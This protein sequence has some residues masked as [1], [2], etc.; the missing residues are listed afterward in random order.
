MPTYHRRP[1]AGIVCSGRRISTEEG[2]LRFHNEKVS[3]VG[4][5]GVECFQ[6]VK[7]DDVNL[8][9]LVLVLH[10]VVDG[11][12]KLSSTWVNCMEAVLQDGE[13]TVLLEVFKHVPGDDML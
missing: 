3:G 10:E 5:H 6:N 7:D 1:H 2:D 13:F 12:D 11:D 9:T 8:G 4:S